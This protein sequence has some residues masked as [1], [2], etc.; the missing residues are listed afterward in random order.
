MAR[1]RLICATTGAL[2]VEILDEPALKRRW[3]RLINV[4]RNPDGSFVVDT[5]EDGNCTA[6]MIA[7]PAP[8]PEW[9]KAADIIG[10]K[11]LDERR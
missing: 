5:D 9:V 6:E 7:E 8:P 10:V 4:T 2:Y 3:Y 11:V 1:Q